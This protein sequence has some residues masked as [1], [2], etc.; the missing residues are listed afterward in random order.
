MPPARGPMCGGPRVC[1]MSD[2]EVLGV[3]ALVFQPHG[4]R[5]PGIS[6]TQGVPV[7]PTEGV[8]VGGSTRETQTPESS[9]YVYLAGREG[10]A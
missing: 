5:A 10:N 9:R 4:R 2:L 7:C 3:K 1:R 6:D 8:C